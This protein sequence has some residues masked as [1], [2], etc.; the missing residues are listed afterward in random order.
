[1]DCRKDI[2][3]H[4]GVEKTR[5]KLN[6]VLR[7]NKRA[8]E[9][10]RQLTSKELLNAKWEHLIPSPASPLDKRSILPV[11]HRSTRGLAQNVALKTPPQNRYPAI[12]RVIEQMSSE[13]FVSAQ[14]QW[15]R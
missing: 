13:T 12:D 10:R 2:V 11:S 6:F 5:R 1:M 15:R 3:I 7:S 9:W 14:S 4:L 8:A